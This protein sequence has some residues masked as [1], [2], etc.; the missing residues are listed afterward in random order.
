MNRAIWG[1]NLR[2]HITITVQTFESFINYSC[3]RIIATLVIRKQNYKKNSNLAWN[4]L[5]GFLTKFRNVWRRYCTHVELLFTS[6]P[7]NLVC[8]L[9]TNKTSEHYRLAFWFMTEHNWC[10]RKSFPNDPITWRLNL[11]S[12]NSLVIK[13]IRKL[14]VIILLDTFQPVLHSVP[15]WVYNLVDISI[16]AYVRGFFVSQQLT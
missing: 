1:R 4:K 2:W 16:S 7:A 5:V 15:L 12:Q 3:C 14:R 10:K 13:C 8:H 9:F 11:I 6:A